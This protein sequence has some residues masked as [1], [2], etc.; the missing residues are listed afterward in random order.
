MTWLVKLQVSEF[1]AIFTNL[2]RFVTRT[3]SVSNLVKIGLLTNERDKLKFD[4]AGQQ[5]CE[6]SIRLP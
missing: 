3:T 1:K 6:L 5:S 2:A 4:K